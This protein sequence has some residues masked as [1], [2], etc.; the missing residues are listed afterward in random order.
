MLDI[1]KVP[2]ECSF[3]LFSLTNLFNNFP[4]DISYFLLYHGNLY[5]L[6]L[7]WSTRWMNDFKTDMQPWINFI[8][9]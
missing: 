6:A 3:K 2:R 8:N 7:I 1:N 4:V 5:F 9:G